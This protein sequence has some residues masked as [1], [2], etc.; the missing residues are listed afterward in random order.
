MTNINTAF[1]TANTCRRESNR[2]LHLE[3]LKALL[4][5]SITIAMKLGSPVVGHHQCWQTASGDLHR[6][7]SLLHSM[8]ALHVHMPNKTNGLYAHFA[9]PTRVH[10][11]SARTFLRGP[12]RRQYSVLFTNTNPNPK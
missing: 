6:G 5:H 10:D 4:H 8:K 3:N 12:F 2:F 9:V 11:F 7:R 1:S